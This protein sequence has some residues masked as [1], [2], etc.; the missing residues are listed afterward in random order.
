MLSPE[1]SLA[2]GKL[3]KTTA[4][5]LPPRFQPPPPPPGT[6]LPTPPPG[7]PAPKPPVGLPAAD[8]YMQTK[9][10][11]RHVETHDFKKEVVSPHLPACLPPSTGLRRV[12]GSRS[13]GLPGSWAQ[14]WGPWANGLLQ[15]LHSWTAPQGLKAGHWGQG[16]EWDKATALWGTGGGGGG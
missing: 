15:N 16:D 9:S 7:Y 11:L 12:G 8:I 2:Q 5:P 6:Q 4:P 14:G 3:E 1:L 13:R 10:K